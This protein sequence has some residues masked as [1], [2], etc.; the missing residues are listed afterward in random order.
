MSKITPCLW[1]NRDAETA[2]AFYVSLVADSRIDRVFRSPVDWPNGKAGDVLTVEFT[3]GGLGCLAM[4][5]GPEF[6][7]NPA[8]SL[9]I[10]C[11]DQ[12][13]VDR[14]WQSILAD[15]GAEMACGWIRDRWGFA[16]Q[17][18]AAPAHGVG[19]V[20]PFWERPAGPKT[21]R[22]GRTK[23]RPTPLRPSRTS[24]SS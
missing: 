6:T 2:A 18:V 13:E 14:I 5:G 21:T 1:F 24:A 7:F 19:L 15:G 20:R 17:I 22:V 4:N 8:V 9:Q 3:L 10:H 11:D 16:W 12:A 23:T